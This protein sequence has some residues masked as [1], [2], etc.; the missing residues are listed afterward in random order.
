V[1]WIILLSD[2]PEPALTIFSFESE[3]EARAQPVLFSLDPPNNS[4]TAS[5]EP[6]THAAAPAKPVLV[7]S[8]SPLQSTAELFQ[9]TDHFNVDGRSFQGRIVT[10][11]HEAFSEPSSDTFPLLFVDP[12][13][14]FDAGL[15]LACCCR[16]RARVRVRSVLTLPASVSG[17]PQLG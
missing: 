14:M 4:A 10:H 3:S 11:F 7:R 2:A 6:P 9:N 5:V 16:V 15:C 13:G 8:N 12:D 1:D 17:L